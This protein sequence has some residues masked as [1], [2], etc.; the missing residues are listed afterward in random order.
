MRTN[1]Q[2][3]SEWLKYLASFSDEYDDRLYKNESTGF[4]MKAGHIA[5]ESAFDC[6]VHFDKVLEVGSGTG[7][8]FRSVRHSF[9]EYILTDGDQKTLA[10]AEMAL[11]N[12]DSSRKICYE[13]M[14]ASNLNF[15]DNT[16]DR[17]VATHILEHLYEP[18]LAI[19]EWM[20]VL[21]NNGT[22]S[23][24]IPTDPEITW[25]VGR[26]LTTRKQAIKRGWS[27]DYIMAREHVN[28]C[29]NLVAFLNFYLPKNTS[30][31]WPLKLLPSID[32]NLFYIFHAVKDELTQELDE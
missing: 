19:K 3:D 25:K 5:C 31:F 2:D 29:N 32:C 17:V 14:N 30:F 4:V 23:I 1:R 20:R 16:F 9:K 10:I 12:G 11:G 21:K 27:Y 22:L 18:H 13:K 28:P 8:H 6:T 15:E 24:L 7:E 26:H